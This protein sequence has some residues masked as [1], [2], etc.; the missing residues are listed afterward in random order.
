M[1]GQWLK[2]LALLP[3][4]LVSVNSAHAKVWRCDF[5][6]KYVCD[7]AE[8]KLVKPT[9]WNFVD[10]GKMTISRCDGQG[11][12]HYPMIVDPKGVFVN[13]IVP[14]KSMSAKMTLNASEYFE[15]VS[16]GMTVFLG[17]GSC[18]PN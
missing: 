4:F 3:F 13:I 11:C 8:C 18:K 9:V 15:V 10:F 6:V 7:P 1:W 17:F 12:D 2:A 16:L 5:S 14:G